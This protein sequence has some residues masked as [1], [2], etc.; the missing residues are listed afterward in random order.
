MSNLSESEAVAKDFRE[1]LEDLQGFARVEINNLTLIARENT[2]HALAISGALQEHIKRVVPHKKLPAL[3][4]LDSIVKVVGTPYTIYFGRKLYH[5]FMDAYASVDQATRRKMDEMLRTWKE[6]VPG[7]LDTRPVFPP[8]ITR[9]IENALLKVRTITLESQQRSQQQL[10]GR[11]RPMNQGMQGMPYRET[12]TPPGAHSQ[13]QVNGYPQTSVPGVSGPSYAHQSQQAP[14]INYPPHL[15]QQTYP[16]RSTPQ[17]T[18]T[19]MAYQ[20]HQLGS[21]GV[22]QAGISI[23]ALKDDI[24]RLIAASQAQIAQS[25]HDP[26]IQTR[27]KALMDLQTILQTQNLPQDQLVLVKNRIAELAVNIRATP[28]QPPI[29][30][31]TPQAPPVAVAPPP[32]AVPKM[33]LDSL[34]G[35]GTLATLMARNSVTPKTSAPHPLPPPAPVA[36]PTPPP[37]RVEFQKPAPTQPLPPPSSDPLALMNMLRKAGMLPPATPAS[38]SAAVPQATPLI[39]FP[40]PANIAGMAPANQPGRHSSLEVLTS[41]IILR[42]SSLKQFHPNLLPFLFESLGPQCTQCGRRFS[43]D[44]EGKK[45]KTAH[46]DWHFRVNQRI[47]EV[48]KRGQHRSWLVDEVDWIKTRETIDKDH[49]IPPEVSDAAVGG[50][51][52]KVPKTQY[53]PVPDDPSLANSVCSICQE[54]F[55]TRW[56]DDAQEFVWLDTM[57][58]GQ[59]IYHATCYNE[60]YKDGGNTTAY[61]WNTGTPEPATGKRKAEDELTSSRSKVKVEGT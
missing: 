13:P 47:A 10:L 17:P 24:H 3:Y 30:T 1:A 2:E 32:T 12:P 40:V 28:A 41:D 55:E 15:N 52:Q 27:L 36:V 22:P 56:L 42:P 34:F 8:D 48:E 19:S 38:N 39:P 50:S 54:K 44:E 7:S 26:S 16:A 53:I 6:P 61:T 25:P 51:T 49:L 29:S 37:Q 46:M 57:K 14:V 60:A 21:F 59:K 9:P 5:T 11:G 20:H 31:P 33:S 18:P 43:K 58:V 4:V 23:D 35:A 45:K